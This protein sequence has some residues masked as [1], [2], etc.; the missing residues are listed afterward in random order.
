ML[1]HSILLVASMLFHTHT[2][3]RASAS[4]L[5]HTHTARRASARHTHINTARMCH[6]AERTRTIAARLSM[7]QTAEKQSAP[8]GF[9]PLRSPDEYRELLAA[10]ASD[11]IT[12][13]KFEADYCRTCRAAAP[14][15][16]YQVNR[17]AERNPQAQFF[18]MELRRKDSTAAREAMVECFKLRNATQLPYVEIFVGSELVET[19]VVAPSRIAFFVGALSEATEALRERRRRQERRRVLTSLRDG[20]WELMRVRNKR[21]RLERWWQLSSLY[22]HANDGAGEDGWRNSRAKRLRHL[23]RLRALRREMR[24]LEAYN[25]RNARRLRLFNRFV[26]GEWRDDAQ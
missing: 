8:L 19:L 6:T 9:V 7:W 22:V 21:A 17:F 1:V 15:L 5:F 4:M 3:R 20:R 18:A 25:E 10:A 26:V 11:A 16:R 14:K 23:L 24:A 12:V 13:V 2:A